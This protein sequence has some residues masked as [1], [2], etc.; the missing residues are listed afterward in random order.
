MENR[1]ETDHCRH[2]LARFCRGQGLDIGCG[3][4]KIS[5]D[6]IGIDLYNP[7]ADVKMDARD[8]SAY[9]DNHFDYIYSSHLL[10]ELENTELTLKEWLR[11]VK[12][13]GNIV[14]YQADDQI[15]FPI[16]HPQC[17]KNHKHHFSPEILW[18]I[19]ENIGGVELI[20]KS[21]PGSE[22]KEWSFELV[23]KKGVRDKKGDDI[24]EGISF[25]IPTR[26]RPNGMEDFAVSVDNTT[27][28]H[29]NIEIIFGFHENDIDSKQ[30]AEDLSK[31]LKISIRG[32][33]I[34]EYSDGKPH[35]PFLWNQ[36]YMKSKY[37]ILGF[38][39]DDVIFRTPGWDEEV[40]GEFERNKTVMVSCND[41]HVQKGLVATL[42]FTHKH[43]HEAMGF[44]LNE[45]FR[46]WYP[47][48]YWDYI[49]RKAGRLKYRDDLITEHM[50]PDAFPDRLDETYRR[51]EDLK[52]GD[53]KYWSTK[54]NQNDM[55]KK[56][57]IL[58]K[59]RIK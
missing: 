10:E 52:N 51:M 26:N 40:R 30:K 32:E 37:P 56:V 54:E 15:Y 24:L 19:F 28:N 21:R 39:G 33:V 16:G 25:L 5:L 14:L 8:L 46:R 34:S 20:H 31:R 47:D 48:T 11:V 12:D 45:R 6:S 22:S 18:G 42:F 4:S 41:V 44:Y 36:V 3:V 55:N 49:F 13:G 35:L 29:E 27:K 53:K 1:G 50:H 23:I 7:N 17:N 43:V 38:F 2:R 59:L 9:P 57:E 58:R